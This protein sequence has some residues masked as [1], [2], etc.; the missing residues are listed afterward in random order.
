MGSMWVLDQ[1]LDQPMNEEAGVKLMYQDNMS[2]EVEGLEEITLDTELGFSSNEGGKEPS[3]TM[4]ASAT[5]KIWIVLM[6][7]LSSVI[8]A[9]GVEVELLYEVLEYPETEFGTCDKVD[10]RFRGIDGRF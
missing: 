8:K 9:Y 4:G 3:P 5:N 1:K 2:M 6:R 10:S 7:I